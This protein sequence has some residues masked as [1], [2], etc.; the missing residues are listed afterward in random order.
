VARLKA[1]SSNEELAQ[2]W[3]S[4]EGLVNRKLAKG[5]GMTFSYGAKQF[6][7]AERLEEQLEARD[8]WPTVEAHFSKEGPDGKTESLVTKACLY[9][10]KE[11]YEVLKVQAKSAVG[12]MEWLSEVARTIAKTG[13]HLSWDV[14]HTGFKV[15]QD[16]WEKS[17]RQ[18]ETKVAGTIYKPA[19]GAD[20]D[21]VDVSKHA[22]A[23]AANVVHSLDAAALM[24]TVQWASTNG[25][26]QFAMIHDSYGTVPAEC[27]LLAQAARQGFYRLY[28]ARNLGSDDENDDYER[29]V[30]A[31]QKYDVVDEL[32]RQFQELAGESTDGDKVPPR[33]ARIGT[34]D[35]GM[36]LVSPNF[37]S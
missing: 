8:D 5:P 32:E 35:P 15:V 6:G 28:C 26:D 23:V 11:F 12:I 29:P 25:M 9:L 34:L 31:P 3:L 37:M 20:T 2:L 19:S 24:L 18:I 4:Y 14:P 21:E 7:F 33:P 16:Y 22:S 36:V 17:E 1:A 27:G 10:A 30:G 13:K